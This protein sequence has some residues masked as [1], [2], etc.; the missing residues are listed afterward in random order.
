MIT[1]QII[2]FALKN[3]GSPF[4]KPQHFGHDIAQIIIPA[5]IY[6][7]K[8]VGKI[9]SELNGNFIT[10]VFYVSTPKMSVMD[11]TCILE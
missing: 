1:V 3:M 9:I 7:T 10:I 2:T 6:T 5:N 8:T 4:E 11:L